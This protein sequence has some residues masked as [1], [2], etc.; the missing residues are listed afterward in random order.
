MIENKLSKDKERSIEE[1]AGCRNMLGLIYAQAKE[2]F[3][4]A[5]IPLRGLHKELLQFYPPASHYLGRYKIGSNSVV[6]K[7]GTKITRVVFQTADAGPMTSAAMKDLVEWYN[8]TL[9]YHPW[10]LA[11]ACEFV[12]R[13]LAIHP[14]QDGNGRVGRGLFTLALLQSPDANFGLVI[15][16]LALDRSIERNRGEYYL[17]LR[18]CSGGKFSQEPKKYKIHYFLEFMLKRMK[19]TLENDIDFYAKR[20]HAFLNL[21][22]APKTVLECFREHPEKKLAMKDILSEIKIPRRTAI[23]AVNQLLKEGFLQRYGQG[24]GTHYQLTF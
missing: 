18:Q 5:E 7:I 21:A 15:P 20:H 17:V 1:V 3:P 14:F 12:F 6:E 8:Q 24:A 23:H 4:L 9:P 10:S 13:F 11:V 2:S 16:Y 22:P 19:E